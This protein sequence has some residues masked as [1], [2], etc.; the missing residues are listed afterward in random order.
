MK[1]ILLSIFAVLLFAACGKDKTPE[2]TPITPATPQVDYTRSFIRFKANGTF[3]ELTGQPNGAYISHATNGL[4]MVFDND[5]TGAD[6]KSFLI[7]YGQTASYT[8]N[9]PITFSRTTANGFSAIYILGGVMHGMSEGIATE[10]TTIT[11]TKIVDLGN[12]SSAIN[13]TFSAKLSGGINL[14]EGE[15]FDVRTK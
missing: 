1:N 6:A 13:G 12:G 5:S 15:F 4:G 11:L 8:L 9:V 10:A 3:V 2:P 14:T 7:G